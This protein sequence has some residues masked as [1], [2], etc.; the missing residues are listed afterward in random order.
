MPSATHSSLEDMYRRRPSFDRPP[1]RAI[2]SPRLTEEEADQLTSPFL[3]YST[4]YTYAFS[5]SYNPDRPPAWEVPNMINNNTLEIAS[6]AYTYNFSAPSMMRRTWQTTKRAVWMLVYAVYVLLH[7]VTVRPAKAVAVLL[8]DIVD[9]IVSSAYRVGG[10]I[11]GAFYNRREQKI[12]Y[13]YSRNSTTRVLSSILWKLLY[14]L[15]SFATVPAGWIANS[16]RKFY[17]ALARKR[18]SLL[19]KKSRQVTRDVAMRRMN[20]EEQYNGRPGANG[21]RLYEEEF[22]SDFVDDE[23]LY[24][25]R[26]QNDYGADHRRPAAS[27]S[28]RLR[29]RRIA[30]SDTD[31]DDDTPKSRKNVRFDMSASNSGR[32]YT[33]Q[34]VKVSK[35]YHIAASLGHAASSLVYYSQVMLCYLLTPVRKVATAVSNAWSGIGYDRVPSSN[36]MSPMALRSGTRYGAKYAEMNSNVASRGRISPV[37]SVLSPAL[38]S[39]KSWST[40][41]LY[42]PCRAFLFIAFAFVD[43]FRWVYSRIPA[44]FAWTRDAMKGTAAFLLNRRGRFLW[45]LLPLL[46]LL[47][48]LL[49]PQGSDKRLVILGHDVSELKDHVTNYASS[50]LDSDGVYAKS[51]NSI[52]DEY[53]RTG[54]DSSY[55]LMTRVT[56]AFSNAYLFVA[57]ILKTAAGFVVNA[58]NDVTVHILDFFATTGHRTY[59]R[60]PSVSSWKSSAASVITSTE[61]Q[62]NYGL[63]SLSDL[64]NTILVGLRSWCTLI[65]N[66]LAAIVLSVVGA[67]QRVPVAVIE[68][69]PTIVK[70]DPKTTTTPSIEPV[71]NM[72]PEVIYVPS[73]TPAIDES[74]LID[75]ITAIVRAKMDQDLKQKLEVELKAL[76]ASYE[77]KISTLKSEKQRVDVD[78]SHL[79]A[80]IRAAIFEYDSDKTAMFDF[81]LESAGASIISTRCSENY[82][83][84]SR[85]EK[86]W[87]IP[88]W[89]SSY[90]PRTVIQRNSKTLFPGECWSFKGPVGYITIS[91]SH[92]INVTSISYEHIGAHQ[93]PNGERPSAPKNFKIWAY[94]SEADMAT[95]VLLGEFVYD[96]KSTPLQFFVIKTQPDYP[97]KIIEMEVTSNYGAEYTSLYRLRVHG[98]LYRSGQQ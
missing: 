7:F 78:Y 81:A 87:D 6:P 96:I 1:I 47:L 91:L 70:V 55:S 15:R 2:D 38:A 9:W 93:T 75:K 69:Q 68:Q 86:I 52:Y 82:N 42:A 18:H 63:T 46:L 37:G 61:K 29:S 73:P 57:T 16:A 62:L 49:L 33:A 95:R 79:E 14:F 58:V 65:W 8:Y 89:Y 24:Q 92:A 4:K 53:W 64:G 13:A 88:L 5:Q 80:L 45:L 76:T 67:F 90:G 56:S 51:L 54:K 30:F 77:Q 72:K 32:S 59:A 48:L 50:I 98:A 19:L 84:Y 85:L 27:S 44:V 35:A 60:L 23:E 12:N 3:S 20:E 36:E 43:L 34:P 17:L 28:Y 39:L 26:V 11:S 97:V 10:A 41:I 31:T 21:R 83:T 22:D 40:Y 71:V 94:K 25:Q 74:K 66:G